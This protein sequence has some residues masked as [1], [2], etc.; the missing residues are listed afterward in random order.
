MRRLGA[1][2]HE[3]IHMTNNILFTIDTYSNTAVTTNAGK[4]S[5]QKQKDPKMTKSVTSR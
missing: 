3:V 5:E 4:L 1:T 2:T